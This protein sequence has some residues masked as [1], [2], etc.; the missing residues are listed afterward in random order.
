[1]EGQ[2]GKGHGSSPEEGQ[3]GPEL[4]E[5]YDGDPAATDDAGVHEQQE[6]AGDEAAC[7]REGDTLG[8]P[9]HCRDAGGRAAAGEVYSGCV[10]DGVGEGGK[11]EDVSGGLVRLALHVHLASIARKRQH[12]HDVGLERDDGRDDHP[13]R[14]DDG[15]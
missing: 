13:Q 15:A 11:K 12:L 5:S 6:G 4:V 1:M 14:G 8:V 2:G 10:E 9:R 3:H 7:Q